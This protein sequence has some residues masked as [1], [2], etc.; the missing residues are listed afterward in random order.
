MP[1]QHLD[2]L[3]G[4]AGALGGAAS[5]RPTWTGLGT[6]SGSSSSLTGGDLACGH[7]SAASHSSGGS[8][9]VAFLLKTREYSA[10]RIT[11]PSG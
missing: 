9:A 10:R 2:A 8:S 3:P 7:V 11:R 1:E 6:Q 4:P 5:D